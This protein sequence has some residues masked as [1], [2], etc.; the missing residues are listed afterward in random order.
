MTPQ[1]ERT[2]AAAPPAGPV[3]MDAMLTPNRAL[4]TRAF[5]I[6]ILAFCAI[7]LALAIAF[8][9]RGAWPVVGFLGLDVLLLYVAFRINYRDGRASERV[10]VCPERLQVTR[11]DPRGTSVHFQVSPAWARIET[12]PEAVLVSAGGSRLSM[13][14]FLS[15][16]ERESFSSALQQAVARARAYRSSTSSIE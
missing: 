7:N 10:H 15:P 13:A 9:L 5:T 3:F 1:W 16:P 4:S 12:T 2:S 6:L 14:S 11:T 8:L